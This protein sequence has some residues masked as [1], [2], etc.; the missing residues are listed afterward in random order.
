MA[1]EYYSLLT[2]LSQRLSKDDLLNLVFSCES[3]LPPSIAEKITTGI[4]LFQELKQRGHLGPTNYDYLR[5]QLVL[6]GRHDLA[7]VLPD[8]FEI[9]FG[10]SNT[11]SKEYFG[12]FVSPT[13][14]DT[15]SVNVSLLKLLHPNTESRILL[16]HLSQQLTSE[17][18]KKLAFLM[19]PSHNQV[20][21]LNFAELL[22]REGGLNSIEVVTRLSS[23]LEVVGR[24]DLAQSLQ[25]LKTPPV[26]PS[27][28]TPQQQ[29]NLKMKMFIHTKQQLYDFHM[30]ALKKVETDSGVRMKL[31]GPIVE[32]IWPSFE[33]TNI[34]VM[35]KSLEIAQ[36]MSNRRDL[37]S[38]IKTSL[39]E[40]SK[41]DKAYMNAMQVTCVAKSEDVLI[42]K[43]CDIIEQLHESYKLFSSMMDVLDWNSVI[44]NE[45]KESVELHKSP[46]GTSAEAASQYIFELSQEVSRGDQICQ[47]KEQLDRYLQALHG[48]YYGACYYIIIIQWLASLYCFATSSSST[49]C[50]HKETLQHIVQQKKDDIIQ[51]YKHISEVIGHKAL[52]KL[53]IPSPE[54]TCIDSD[55]KPLSHAHPLVNLFNVLLIK[56][57][58]VAMLGPNHTTLAGHCSVDSNEALSCGSEMIMVSASAMKMQVEAFREKVISSDP[59]TSQVMAALTERDN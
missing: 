8:Q 27:L 38:L 7:S 26:I 55:S 44:R 2:E 24:V 59:L 17:D 54:S 42:E 19:Y 30:K 14:P 25:S 53:N 40:V 16:M 45:L 3:I 21:V 57:L 28:S 11:R 31:L 36:S 1:S 34:Q 10:R 15:N 9:L 5:K 35:A 18:A 4:Q 22:E 51:S 29:L 32:R 46:F 37:D 23:C 12:C 39:V 20:T 52:E 41:I 58:A 33:E 49:F 56:V 47:E 50:K 6:I 13:A 48:V 43:V